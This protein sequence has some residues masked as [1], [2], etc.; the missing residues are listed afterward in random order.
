MANRADGAALHP[1]QAIAWSI[2]SSKKFEPFMVGLIIF[3]AVLIGLETSKDFMA[4]YD[5]V[6]HLLNDIILVIFIVEAVLKI[7]AVAP[8]WSLYFGSGWNLF[9]LA[10]IVFSLIPAT[11]DFA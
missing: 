11:D 5:G 3:N 4:S 7:T 8:R 2:V 9:D 1:V 10:V 6:F